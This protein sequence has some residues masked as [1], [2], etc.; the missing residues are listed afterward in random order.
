MDGVDLLCSLGLRDE[1]FILSVGA[2]PDALKVLP[3]PLRQAVA[4][5]VFLIKRSKK[6]S[7]WALVLLDQAWV[8]LDAAIPT[9]P[10]LVFV[11]QDA[12][13]DERVVAQLVEGARASITADD[14]A[15]AAAGRAEIIIVHLYQH[16]SWVLI[17]VIIQDRSGQKAVSGETVRQGR[18]GVVSTDEMS[19]DDSP[20]PH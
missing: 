14:L 16:V 11:A 15:V 12:V 10:L 6:L 1:V 7:P 13:G 8:A 19:R 18:R 3:G 2:C 5:C 20:T 4:H 17:A 9:V